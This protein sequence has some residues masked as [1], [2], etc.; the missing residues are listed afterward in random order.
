MLLCAKICAVKM[1]FIVNYGAWM[2][3]NGKFSDLKVTELVVAMRWL[4]FAAF[5]L[6]CNEKRLASATIRENCYNSF[7]KFYSQFFVVRAT[8]TIERWMDGRLRGERK[9]FTV[10]I[11]RKRRGGGAKCHRQTNGECHGKW[12]LPMRFWCNNR[13]HS[14]LRPTTTPIKNT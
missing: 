14:S 10:E 4:G 13:N 6:L 2:D 11:E 12:S 5:D 3:E 1:A 7:V 8:I 9:G